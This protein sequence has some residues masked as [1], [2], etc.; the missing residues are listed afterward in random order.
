M[1]PKRPNA[2]EVHL[3][4]V[5][6]SLESLEPDRAGFGADPY[7]EITSTGYATSP[8]APQGGIVRGRDLYRVGSV[9]VPD[10]YER[11]WDRRRRFPEHALRRLCP[12]PCAIRARRPVVHKGVPDVL[13]YQ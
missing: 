2:G 5:A 11:A 12:S 7:N 9:S 1:K 13:L 3:C 6:A 8:K 4:S 10:P